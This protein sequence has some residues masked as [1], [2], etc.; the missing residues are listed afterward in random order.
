MINYFHEKFFVGRCRSM[1]KTVADSEVR[2]SKQMIPPRAKPVGRVHAGDIMQ[3]MYNAAHKVAHKHAG[4]DVTAV[5]VDEMVFL[6]PLY[7]GAV[8]RA[9]AF[10]TFVGRTSMEV[11]VNLY[12]E[13]LADSKAV[14]TAYFVMVALDEAQRPKPVPPLLLA[15]ITEKA[16]FAAGQERYSS[17]E[18]LE[19]VH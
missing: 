7:K 15:S 9:H 11:E 2:F 4:C 16:R 19:G 14:L 5:R 6:R 8:V 17:R 18:K 12:D 13:D 1:P 3:L 10:L